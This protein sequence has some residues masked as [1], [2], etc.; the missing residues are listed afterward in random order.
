MDV[1]K[2]C[3]SEGWE[4]LADDTRVDLAT[5][6]RETHQTVKSAVLLRLV[7]LVSWHLVCATYAQWSPSSRTGRRRQPMQNWLVQVYFG[8]GY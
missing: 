4:M 7:S 5:C 1:I 6:Q 2:M 8:A 3:K